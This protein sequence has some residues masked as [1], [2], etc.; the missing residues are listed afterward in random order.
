MKNEFDGYKLKYL[1]DHHDSS[2]AAMGARS[3][4]RLVP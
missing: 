2:C 3:D 4:W 1:L